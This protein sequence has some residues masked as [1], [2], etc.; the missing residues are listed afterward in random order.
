MRPLFCIVFL[1]ASGITLPTFADSPLQTIELSKRLFDRGL[2]AR[3][4][5][6]MATAAKLRRSVVLQPGSV[7]GA[8]TVEGAPLGW[9]DMLETAEVAAGEDAAMLS[10]I[11]DVRTEQTK[12]VRTGPV[13]SIVALPSDREATFGPLPFRGGTFAEVYLEGDG[14]S[15]L[16]LYIFD[17]QSRLV[18][19]DTDGSD[20][21]HCGWTPDT[22][23]SFTL[24][25]ENKGPS[26]NR[27]ALMTN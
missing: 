1:L 26:E 2:E 20:I 24:K 16:N 13:Y 12:G 25:V 3:D 10:V 6:L 22:P 5:L 7:P 19:S 15:D 14:Q 23:G 4:P 11:A 9:E 18:C 17:A 21:A 27:F 8:E